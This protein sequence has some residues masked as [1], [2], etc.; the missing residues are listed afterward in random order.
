[1]TAHSIQLRIQLLATG[2]FISVLPDSILRGNAERWSLKA[3]PIDLRAR[4]PAW[5]IIKLKNR[6]VGPV[7]QLFV[8]QLRNV[9]KTWPAQTEHRRG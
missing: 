9:A 8:D 7:V 2:G 5:S 1:V 6:T 3:L 4:P